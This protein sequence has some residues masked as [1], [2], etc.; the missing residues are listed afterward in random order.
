M[1]VGKWDDDATD[2]S[3]SG[4]FDPKTLHSS[5][6][7]RILVKQDLVEFKKR[8]YEMKQLAWYP[9]FLPAIF[10]ELRIQELPQIMT[11]IRRFLY[12]VEKTTGTHK[13]YLRKLGLTKS[14]G[15]SLR[16]VWNDPDFEAAP[17]ELTSIASDC[18]YYG[19][20][21]QTR[22]NLLNFIE[23]INKQLLKESNLPI[24][25]LANSMLERK[26]EFMRI[27]MTEVQNRSAYLGRRVE[28]Q[29][30]TV[31]NLS[32]FLSTG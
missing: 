10:I 18:A 11:R 16:E 4:I 29:V 6:I 28:V 14:T 27:W 1:N 19:Y 8:L 25:D 21:C 22:Q 20:A 3:L 24:F 17:A 15:R 5:C 7:L 13:N 30:Q 12:R 23:K 2:I 31:C 9:L 32:F 26:I